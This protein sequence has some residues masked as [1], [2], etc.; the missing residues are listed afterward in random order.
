MPIQNIIFDLGNV[1]IDLDVQR[2]E[3]AFQN[4]VG[5]SFLHAKDE[6]LQIFL[7]FEMGVIPEANFLNYFI[8]KAIEPVE[9]ID[10]VQAWNA[11]LVGIPLQRLQMMKALGS[12]FRTMILSNTNETHLRWVSKYLIQ[13]YD[14]VSLDAFVDGAYYSNEM[15]CRK[16]DR[17]IY[18]MVID[19]EGIIPSETV[20][21]DD[22][23]DNVD[24]AKECGIDAV[25]IDPQDEILDVISTYLA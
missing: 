24:V 12:R 16:P 18:D 7:D 15:G 17:K 3:A 1:I 14:L 8:E 6:D 23:I 22:Q 11:M 9:A 5:A 13:H 20:F 21:F 4:L 10:I 2:S 19:R 25:L